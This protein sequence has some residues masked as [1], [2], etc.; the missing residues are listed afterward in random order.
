MVMRSIRQ[1]KWLSI[2]FHFL[3][4]NMDKKQRLIEFFN[5]AAINWNDMKRSERL[6]ERLEEIP[7]KKGDRVL[8][9]GCG[10]GV[11]SNWLYE[12]SQRQVHAIDVSPNMI[13]IAINTH[14]VNDIK[15]ECIDFYE[16]NESGYDL[17]V[18]FDAYPHF[19]DTRTFAKKANE[20][21]NKGGYLVIL[22]D[23]GRKEL[24]KHHERIGVLSKLFS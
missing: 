19:L 14:H 10:T 23:I 7:I 9:I 12:R 5:K 22:H 3:G 24:D 15:F 16:M 18:C 17:L 13:D 20:L 2:I 1:N 4:K 11:I 8:D 6:L 21:L